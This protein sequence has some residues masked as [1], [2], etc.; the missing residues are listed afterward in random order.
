[1]LSE[2]PARFSMLLAFLLAWP[3]AAAAQPPKPAPTPPALQ[4]VVDRMR[5]QHSCP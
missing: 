5:H 4:Q 1:M 3:W 2:L